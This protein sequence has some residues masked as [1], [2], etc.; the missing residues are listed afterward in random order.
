MKISFPSY[1]QDF[2]CL[3]GACPDT[4]CGNWCVVID[5]ETNRFYASIPG[6]LG[7]R[8][9]NHLTT[10]EENEVCLS[11]DGRNCA[12]QDSN[13]LCSL[14]CAFGEKGLSRVCRMYPRFRYEFGGSAEEGISLSCPEACRLILNSEFHLESL[15]N[16]DPPSLND[17][18]AER[19][20]AYAA[21]R[22]AALDIAAASDYSLSEK[23][24]RILILAADL[25]RSAD[26]PASVI[27]GIDKE[28][29]ALT[30]KPVKKG[31]F[32]R[33][34]ELFLEME[35]LDESDRTDL[36]SLRYSPLPTHSS[37][38]ERIFS[39]YIYKYFL[40][41]A[42][43]GKLLKHVQFAAASLLIIHGLIANSQSEQ[44]AMRRIWRFSRETEH[45][46]QNLDHFLSHSGFRKQALFLRL[47]T[48]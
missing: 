13:G 23:A 10:D 28:V 15:V 33:L 2:K 48:A 31:D 41:S 17:I 19:Y 37:V 42:Y 12:M 25:E 44:E 27:A 46:E 1:Y 30:V 24:A 20:L 35:Y 29:S 8:I 14:Q 34:L 16:R 40:Q 3:C 5:D 11:F 9:R 36:H 4:C 7:D 26:D 38:L 47:V 39:Y 21:G 32:P 6:E 18:D 22:K 45:S 43:D